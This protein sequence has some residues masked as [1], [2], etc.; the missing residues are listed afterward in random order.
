MPALEYGKLDN[1]RALVS[2]GLGRGIF[3]E[4][5]KTAVRANI[6]LK[7]LLASND[8]HLNDIPLKEWDRIYIALPIQGLKNTGM[9]NVNT[10]S[11][12]VCILK[13]AACQLIDEHKDTSTMVVEG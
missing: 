4:S 5:L 9:I 3:N 1:L 7:R 6:S 8:P 13:E 12:K 10:P 11:V 2:T